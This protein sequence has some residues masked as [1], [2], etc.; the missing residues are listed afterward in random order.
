M[1]EIEKVLNLS[2]ETEK[3]I[4]IGELIGNK[5]GD[6]D[7][8]ENL[9]ESEK[10]FLYVDILEREVNNGGFDQFFYNS[11]GEFAHEILDAY[12]KIGAE[13]TA[14]II[15]RAIKLFPTLPVPK[16]WEA[17]QDIMLAKESN[18]FLWNELDTEFYKYEDNISELIIKYVEKNKADFE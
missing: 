4:A 16:N 12:Q 9:T 18:S 6:D 2:D 7:S 1:T 13:K 17:R 5:I 10:T 15:N 8:L 11:S 3:I 14:D